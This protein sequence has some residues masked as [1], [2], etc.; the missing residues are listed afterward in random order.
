MKRSLG[1]LCVLF[2]LVYVVWSVACSARI[3][4]GDDEAGTNGPGFD[5]DPSGAGTN[6]FGT[7]GLGTDG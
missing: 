4:L 2:C 6:G 7:D 5:E 3:S 1:I